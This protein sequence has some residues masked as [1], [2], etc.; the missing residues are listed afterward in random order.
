M[1]HL[2]ALALVWVELSRAAGDPLAAGREEVNARYKR[3]QV[4]A[5]A[6]SPDALPACRAALEATRALRLVVA[7]NPNAPGGAQVAS[8]LA[9]RERMLLEALPGVERAV[10]QKQAT[11][12]IVN[13]GAVL[14]MG[15]RRPFATAA[16][17]DGGPAEVVHFRE[18]SARL[19]G[20]AQRS[21][22]DVLARL[23]PGGETVEVRGHA[24]D[25]GGYAREEELSLQ[26]AQAVVAWLLDHGAPADRVHWQ[27]MGDLLPVAD[28]STAKGRRANRRVDFAFARDDAPPEPGPPIP[29]VSVPDPPALEVT[30][31]GPL[32]ESVGR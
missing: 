5:S 15:S 25:R 7:Q 18:G 9:E 32:L 21:L 8:A 14:R 29:G 20:R 31:D 12:P 19:S 16:P 28:G 3:C 10:A 1:I 13:G 23:G 24:D 6:L 26:R 11:A 22:E 27:G 4:A 30:L 17:H 2:L